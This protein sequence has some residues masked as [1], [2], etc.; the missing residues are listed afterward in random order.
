MMF[1]LDIDR[2][3]TLQCQYGHAWIWIDGNDTLQV[4]CR[5]NFCAIVISTY[6]RAL[7]D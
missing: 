3:Y 2:A 6:V 5:S 1:D 4:F 7:R